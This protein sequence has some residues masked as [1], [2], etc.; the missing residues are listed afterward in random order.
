MVK[1]DAEKN[2]QLFENELTNSTSASILRFENNNSN[3]GF[4]NLP[5]WRSQTAATNTNNLLEEKKTF[6]NVSP[7][8]KSAI[9]LSTNTNNNNANGNTSVSAYFKLPPHNYVSA[10]SSTSSSLHASKAKNEG[11]LMSTSSNYNTSSTSNQ[12]NSTVSTGKL[13]RRSQVIYFNIR[14]ISECCKKY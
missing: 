3:N 10:S 5:K 14:V 9:K 13:N 12:S 4:G 1:K 6:F 8:P 11:K 7:L 2:S